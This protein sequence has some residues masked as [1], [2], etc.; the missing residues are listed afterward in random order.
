MAWL[1]AYPPPFCSKELRD[2]AEAVLWEALAGEGCDI[3]RE[4]EARVLEAL[5]R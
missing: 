4:L 2:Q 1:T 5:C 3:S